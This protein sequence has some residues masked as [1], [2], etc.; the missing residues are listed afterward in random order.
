[1]TT[2]TNLIARLRS[3]W[4]TDCLLAANALEAL[5]QQVASLNEELQKRDKCSYMGPMRDCPTHGIGPELAAAQAREAKMREAQWRNIKSVVKTLADWAFGGK[6]HPKYGTYWV[7]IVTGLT[8][9]DGPKFTLE[10]LTLPTDNSALMERLKAERENC[11][12]AMWQAY[13][14]GEESYSKLHDVIRSMT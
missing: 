2:H 5:E 8:A 12:D 3:G 7:S 10:A 6:N 9:K 1:M 4:T 14:D 13:L 11:A